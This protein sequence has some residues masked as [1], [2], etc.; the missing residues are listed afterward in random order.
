MRPAT[1]RSTPRTALCLVVLLAA[2]LAAAFAAACGGSSGGPAP[3]GSTTAGATTPA[4]AASTPAAS[5]GGAASPTPS[6]TPIGSVR[7]NVYFIRHV[8][9]HEYIVCARRYAPAT[10]AMGKLAIT[11]LLAGPDASEKKAG[12]VSLVPAGTKLRSLKIAG[13]IA[14]VDL[15]AAYESGGGTLSMTGRLAQVVYTLTQFPTVKGVA[16]KVNGTKVAV[17]GGEGIE[18]GTPQ[19]RSD[20]EEL[21]APIF[22]D[23]PALGDAVSSPVRIFGTANVFEAQFTAQ[24]LDAKGKVLVQKKVKAT[25]GTGTRGTFSVLLSFTTS[26]TSG[27]IVVFD[28][29]AKD[30][31]IIDK[32]SIPVVFAH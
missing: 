2:G 32:V 24:V 29:S 7:V 6:T 13:G 28:N 27:K 12:F 22:I 4:A 16:F 5:A 26:A 15:N 31:S 9:T 14:T 3:G 1:K 23:G 30:G 19:K 20:Y 8:G 11:A 21:T 10:V 25:S 18:I 17:F